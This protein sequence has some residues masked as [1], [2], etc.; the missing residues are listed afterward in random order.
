MR[1]I[2]AAGERKVSPR[3]TSKVLPQHRE[4]RMR[5]TTTE[6]VFIDTLYAVADDDGA[7]APINIGDVMN[8]ANYRRVIPSITIGIGRAWSATHW[9]AVFRNRALLH[10]EHKGRG[11]LELSEP[12]Q[13]ALPGGD[14][15]AKSLESHIISK[16]DTPQDSFVGGTIVRAKEPRHIDDGDDRSPT[17]IGHVLHR[18][19]R[20]RALRGIARNSRAPHRTMAGPNNRR[21]DEGYLTGP[22]GTIK[23]RYRPG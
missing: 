19:R 10:Y 8:D 15:V 17:V 11:H 5:T 23:P 2:R 12:P 14:A 1:A 6:T 3:P 16:E 20:D 13:L 18:Q 21:H 22:H 7:S 4:N 9:S